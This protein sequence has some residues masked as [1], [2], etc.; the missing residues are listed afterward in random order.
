METLSY[1]EFLRSKLIGKQIKFQQKWNRLSCLKPYEVKRD[2]SVTDKLFAGGNPK[3]RKIAYKDETLGYHAIYHTV[4][5][6]EVNEVSDWDEEAFD[7]ITV[8]GFTITL[9][10]FDTLTEIDHG[11]F[12]RNI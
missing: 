10:I 7:I 4:E 6:A 5:I 9:N 3:F 11:V 2:S 8:D 1:V 12:M